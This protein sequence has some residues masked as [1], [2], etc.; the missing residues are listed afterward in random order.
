VLLGAAV[1][2]EQV[3]AGGF[4]WQLSVLWGAAVMGWH[5]AGGLVGQ[6]AALCGA[7]VPGAQGGLK[8]GCGAGATASLDSSDPLGTLGVTSRSGAVLSAARSMPARAA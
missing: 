5:E 2:G 8:A 1:I 6:V 3:T 7:A 4:G